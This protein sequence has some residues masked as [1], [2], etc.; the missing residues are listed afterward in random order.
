M[1]VMVDLCVCY[2]WVFVVDLI[3][4]GEEQRMTIAYSHCMLQAFDDLQ[5]SITL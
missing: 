2:S 4:G 3:C 5:R 1:K